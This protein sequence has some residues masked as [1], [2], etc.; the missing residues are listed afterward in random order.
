MNKLTGKPKRKVV[1]NP[2]PSYF[3]YKKSFRRHVVMVT[4]SNIYVITNKIN[5]M[6]YVG[7]SSNIP[8]RWYRHS[9]DYK[10]L[11]DRY[12]YRAMNKYSFENF[13]FEVFET[14]I[15]IEEIHMRETYWIKEL[16]T[17]APNGYNMTDG[18]EGSFNRVVS[19]ETKAKISKNLKG[20]K[21]SEETKK[22]MSIRNIERYK[23]P[24][25]RKKISNSMKNNPQAIE[26]AT[27]NIQMYNRNL[28]KEEKM[29]NIKKATAKRSKEIVAQGLDCNTI[30]TFNSIREAS[31]WIR[32]NTPYEKACHTN[33]S[34]ACRGKLDYIYGY[35]WFPKDEF[36]I[37]VEGATTIPNGST[38]EKELPMEVPSILKE[39]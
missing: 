14:D 19:D 12:L 17:K 10:R 33:I 1:G 4:T 18:G 9:V 28:S 13:N 24:N 6:K 11:K 7:Q 20:K 39:G 2:V 5:G 31:R 25:E 36:I 8:E 16:G 22:S 32:E 30:M 37:K 38:L 27:S 26:K 3:N 34:K 15:P 29:K 23:D 35:K 21:H